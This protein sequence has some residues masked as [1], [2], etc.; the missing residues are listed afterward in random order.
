MERHLTLF[1]WGRGRGRGGFRGEGV[2]QII[3]AFCVCVIKW[4]PYYSKSTFEGKKSVILSSSYSWI[5][6][7]TSDWP[8]WL[9]ISQYVP[10]Q[11]RS[12]PSQSVQSLTGKRKFWVTEIADKSLLLKRTIFILVYK[13]YSFRSSYERNSLQ[14]IGYDICERLCAER[15]IGQ[16]KSENPNNATYM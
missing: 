12:F 11:F 13:A 14:L 1:C 15:Y 5:Q 4:I 3:A 8:L 10:P 9:I 6:F 7:E 2:N 16:S